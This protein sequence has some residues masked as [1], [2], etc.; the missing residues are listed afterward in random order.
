VRRRRNDNRGVTAAVAR[1]AG[2]LVLPLWAK[3]AHR[4]VDS[5]ALLAAIAASL[6]IIVNAVFLQTGPRPAPFL[7]TAS[8]PPATG[9]LGTAFANPPVRS[10]QGPRTPQVGP[11]PHNDPIALLI[12]TSSRIMAVQR[13]LSDYGYGQVKLNGVLDPP[14]SAAIEKFEREHNLPVTGRISDRLLADL[15]V[16]SGRPLE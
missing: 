1:L 8:P 16:M 14:T 10:A 9:V 5:V 6:I 3:A 12:D 15:A 4:P 11:T 7:M 2:S 13:V